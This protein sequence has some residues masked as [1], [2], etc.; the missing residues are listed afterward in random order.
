SVAAVAI[1]LAASVP[2]DAWSKHQATQC[3]MSIRGELYPVTYLGEYRQNPDRSFYPGDAF[4]YLFTWSDRSD[5]DECGMRPPIL[6]T[7]RLHLNHTG[8]LMSAVDSLGGWK[9]AGTAFVHH[10][11][12]LVV[13]LGEYRSYFGAEYVDGC[14]VPYVKPGESWNVVWVKYR[15][16][17]EP[18]LVK[19][20]DSGLGAYDKSRWNSK[21]NA[22]GATEYWVNMGRGDG[23][24]R[25]STPVCDGLRQEGIAPDYL[26][27]YSYAPSSS[28]TVSS[29]S[30][31]IFVQETYTWEHR[32]F[33]NSTHQHV[34]DVKADPGS[35]DGFD[36]RVAE[37]CG[38]LGPDSGC[39]YG[40]ATIKP[41]RESCL[42]ANIERI[43][44]EDWLRE[45][46]KDGDGIIDRHE[47]E[48]DDPP[49]LYLPPGISAGQYIPPT[50]DVCLPPDN[51]TLEAVLEGSYWTPRHRV[52]GG[53][54]YPIRATETVVADRSPPMADPVLNAILTKPPLSH[55]DGG[56]DAKNIDGSYYH[57]DPIHI[58]HEPSWKWADERYKHINFTV[59][60]HHVKMPLEDDFHCIPEHNASSP[61]CEH[62]LGLES[63]MWRSD[64]LQFGNGDGM[65]VYVGDTSFPFA[66]YSYSF[67][68][69]AYN[70]D[71]AAAQSEVATTYADLV[72]YE[73][74]YESVYSYP[75]LADEQE[76]AF[77]DRR[78]IVV[79]YAGSLQDGQ[80]Y[81]ERRSFVN[82]WNASGG[83]HT[84][85]GYEEF[86]QTHVLS[87]GRSAPPDARPPV[88]EHGPGA[89]SAMFTS[90]GYGVLYMEWPVSD[91]VFAELVDERTNKTARGA[92]YENIT[93]Q[94]EFQSV[95]FAGHANVTLFADAMRYPEMPFTKQ[96][97]VRS[98][99]QQGNTQ[100]GDAITLRVV[101]YGGIAGDQAETVEAWEE[102]SGG[103]GW[104]PWLPWGLGGG[105][106][107]VDGNENANGTAAGAGN[108]TE[109]ASGTAGDDAAMQQA[110][111]PLDLEGAEYLED[112]IRDKVMHDT[113]GDLNVTEAVLDD[114]YGMTQE[115]TGRGQVD[116]IVLRTSAYFSDIVAQQQVNASE[117]LLQQQIPDDTPGLGAAPRLVLQS[118]EEI[119]SGLVDEPET[120]RMSTP[121]DVG[122]SMLP[123]T[124]VYISVNGGPE[125]VM[126]HKYYAFGVSESIDIN[127]RTDNTMEAGRIGSN[128]TGIIVR[129]PDNF[130]GIVGLEVNGTVA[131]VPCTAGCTLM[132]V[133][134]NDTIRVTAYNAWGGEAHAEVQP[135]E[136]RAA[137]VSEDP[138]WSMFAGAVLML[139]A[140]AYVF[141]KI[142][143]RHMFGGGVR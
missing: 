101:P 110:E 47:T 82:Y 137:P 10:P 41:Y 58:R 33:P 51:I 86:N 108:T 97:V 7:E 93:A 64:T 48:E 138:T 46:D 39:M 42:Y 109:P 9:R 25:E 68:M 13:V 106:G 119:M 128:G 81:G 136:F 56:Y 116:A 35:R 91:H 50:S 100:W 29:S 53:I 57:D 142:F 99:D 139:V 44:G 104:L 20:D 130:G 140:S 69:T 89:Q 88:L 70:V 83:G 92:K 133:P 61:L 31:R 54:E 80:T 59:Q 26:S 102:A 19:D 79:K 11:Y 78:G 62:V 37:A 45:P 12:D 112:Y 115:W 129:Q 120:M 1:V 75:V 14:H 141:K 24:S 17:G 134:V 2:E 143:G 126:H 28:G 84:P 98:I 107:D 77:D 113:G 103:N 121:L 74:V 55:A 111:D 49:P 71:G 85:F 73:P 94:S 123:P 15:L 30:N 118:L 127:V 122:L 40:T 76:Y 21:R 34:F 23:W 6:N 63:P 27:F 117:Q 38:D 22:A 36:A 43:L 67:N 8:T 95:R 72:P 4:Y 18:F 52:Q 105:G 114:T 16:H 3:I 131:R 66:N 65:S 90:A 32:Q 124:S 135:A 132:S 60:R 125:R 96:L 87:A 5:P